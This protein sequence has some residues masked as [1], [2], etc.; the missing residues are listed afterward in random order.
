MSVPPSFRAI[1]HAWRFLLRQPALLRS[2]VWLL[3]L[4]FLALETLD[5]L[6]GASRPDIAAIILVLSLAFGIMTYWGIACVLVV[7]RR[8]LQAKAGR[9]RTSFRAVQVQ[10]RS[11]IVPLLLTDILRMCLTILWAAPLIAIVFVAMMFIS[12]T[13][14]SMVSLMQSYPWIPVLLL[15]TAVPPLLY[16]METLLAPMVI[17]YEKTGFR[18]ALARSRQLTRAH[19]LR[20]VGV[21]VLFSAVCALPS[22]LVRIT[23][24]LIDT[25]SGLYALSMIVTA[26]LDALGTTILLLSFTQYYKAIRGT[27]KAND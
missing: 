8:M 16:F 7:G 23:F 3:F 21:F 9:L 25:S 20:T 6:P 15:V 26:G 17:A 11:L 1:A 18:P 10:A 2:C 27:T 14:I 13:A 22:V 12:D 4:P 19:R 24:T 5:A